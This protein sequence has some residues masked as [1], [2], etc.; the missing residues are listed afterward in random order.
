MFTCFF[1]FFFS[2]QRWSYRPSGPSI[3]WGG[4]FERKLKFLV[5]FSSDQKDWRATRP[6][7]RPFSPK[8]SNSNFDITILFII[9]EKPNNYA[10]GYNMNPPLTY[11]EE[12]FL[13]YKIFPLFTHSICYWEVWIRFRMGGGGIFCWEFFHGK[14]FHGQRSFQWVKLSGKFIHR[15][16]L[17]EFLNNFFICLAFSFPSQ[18]CAWSFKGNGSR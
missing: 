11:R 2:F 13:C 10:F 7:P 5:P 15:G 12:S 8:S 1:F 18:F 14:I 9:I 6:P 3:S 16:S 4:S 17:P